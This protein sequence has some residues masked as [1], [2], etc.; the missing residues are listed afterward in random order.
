MS[1]IVPGYNYDIFISYRQKDNRHDGWVTEFVDNLKGELE[2]TFKEEVSVYFD[3]NPHDG[4]LE[5][6]D[7]DE[8]LKEKL[9]CLVFIPI[10]SRTYCDPKSFAWKHEFRAF[11]EQASDDQFGLKIKL[12]N[13]NVSSRVLPVQIHDLD[14]EDIS[15][16]ESV[17]GSVL[18]GIEFIYKE[19]GVNKPLTEDDDEKK[20]LNGTKYRIQINKI[21]N[22]IKEIISAIEHYSLLQEEVSQDTAKPV[23]SSRKS[24]KTIIITSAVA[25]ALI[26]LG[27]LFI[28]K[29][30]KPEGELEKSIAVLPF[31]NESPI[32]SNKYF[33]NGI[34][35]E[36]L[37]NLQTIKEFRVLSRTSTDKYQG[38]DKSTIPEIAKEL[39]VNYIVEGSGQ[40]YGTAFRLRVQLIKAK[41]KE[42][43]L[44]AKSFEKEILETNDIFSIQSQIAEDI[45][46]ELKTT[47]SPEEIQKLKKTRTANLEAY[48]AFLKGLFF[49]EKISST[50]NEKAI[51][52]FKEAIRLDSTFALPW[53]YLS[54][55]Y[56]RTANNAN[57]PEFKE[58]KLTALKALEIDPTSGTAIVNLAEILDNEYNFKE[59]EEKIRLALEYDPSNL[60]VLRNAGRFY[61][62]FGDSERSIL[63]CKQALQIDPNNG[64]ALFYMAK[65]YF[66]AGLLP[67]AWTTL[68]KYQELEYPG[69][70]DL[71]YQLLLV[72]EKYDEILNESDTVESDLRNIAI[73]AANFA[74]DKKSVAEK[75]CENL[76]E[77]NIKAY[78][79]AFIYAY[80]NEPLKVYE[81]L[82]RSFA[83]GERNITY[84]GV[85]PAFKKYRN[86]PRVLKLLQDMQFPVK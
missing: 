15:M 78:W 53:T 70:T 21:A 20:N 38:P 58:A 5:T 86:Q 11:I 75:L 46:A 17:I 63:Y 35:E 25:I 4:L 66:Y 83:L 7:V 44:W 19:P 81:W 85:D 43:H 80:G 50:E 2:S 84:L 72:E 27:I 47:I 13:G 40:K 68:K 73:A 64:G 71:Y 42:A 26:I 55:V 59:A 74:T 48:D 56:W 51:Y 57:N 31:I 77:N 69:L 41:G 10:I 60:Y 61:T 8:S 29:L 3:I 9:K 24:K 49:Y 6:H 14:K 45:A 30:I 79:V 34:M 16:C 18:R 12:P 23:I 65:A 33:I 67:E 82:E 1:S 32:D 37:N 22:A 36:V 52:W 76:I 54:M 39:G 62:I 28:P